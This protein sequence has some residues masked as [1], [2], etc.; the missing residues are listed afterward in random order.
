MVLEAGFGDGRFLVHLS[1]THPTWN[2]LGADVSRGSV[3]RARRRL[4]RHKVQHVRLFQGKA[5]F[6]VRNIIPEGGLHRLYVNF[7]DPWPKRRHRHRRLIQASFLTLLATR[8]DDGGNVL[9]TT[10]DRDYFEF[11]TR[12]ALDSGLYTIATP[13]T[14]SPIL[15]TKYANKW[16]QQGRKFFHLRLTLI[17][18]PTLNV[19]PNIHRIDM[20]HDQLTGFLPS[21]QNF[22]SFVHRFATGAVV[23]T[24]AFQ[25][26]ESDGLVFTVRVEEEDLTQEILVEARQSDSKVIV[27]VSTFGQPLSTPGTREAVGAIS[28][29]LKQGRNEAL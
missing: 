1:K 19:A 23:V 8:L 9:F 25:R 29:W 12:E 4:R 5:E 14:P 13:S 7:P 22:R 11:A 17:A 20:H 26:L 28:R 3:A 10:D 15:G 2:L 24:G 18:S 6:L 16:A 27:E 21:L